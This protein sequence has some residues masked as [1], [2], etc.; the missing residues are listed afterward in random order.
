M[1]SW[2]IPAGRLF[3]VDIRIHLTFLFLLVFV[4]FTQSVAL[5]TAGAMRG[6]ALVA[7]IFLCVVLHELGHALVARR[8]GVAVRS[9]I[10][11]PIGGVTLMEDTGQR[12]ADS[13]RDIRISIAG[14]LV[15]LAIAVVSG[16]VILLFLPQ[17][18]LWGRPLVTP[19][20]CRARCFGATYFLAPSTC[21]PP[22]PWTAAACCARSLPSVW[23]MSAP[24]VWP[25]PSARDSPCCSSFSAC[26]TPG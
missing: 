20:T 2:S 21:C 6:L 3:G 4:W 23:S 7:I 19:A 17:V 12:T 9:I 24:P 5:G 13:A 14:P 16:V 25:S 1:R 22:I 8:S 26:G 15:N 10:L 11:L 18:N